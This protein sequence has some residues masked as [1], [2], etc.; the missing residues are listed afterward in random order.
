MIWIFLLYL[1]NTILM[2]IL[3]IREVRRP[4]KAL[5]WLVF[6]LVLPIIGFGLYLSTTNPMRIR[7]KRLTPSNNELDLLPDSFSHSATVI[8]N[9]LHPLTVGGLR[10]ARVEVLINGI[11]TYQNLIN[12]LEKAEKAID[13]EY[14][15][16]KYD[17][18]GKQFTD[19]LIERARAGVQ[20]RFLRDGVGSRKFPRQ[21]IT[22]MMD[23]GIECRTIFPMR[24]PWFLS[25]WNYRDHC[26][27]VTIDGEE[28]FTGGINVGLEYT[29]LKPDVGFW[30]DTHLR[31]KGNASS[32]LQKIFEVHW[33]LAV[34]ERKKASKTYTK[35][36]NL[37]G[38]QNKDP[39][40]AF[41][42]WSEE[43]SHELSDMNEKNLNTESVHDAYV[44]TLEGNP[45]VPTP[46]TR[47]AYFI[48]LTQAT[49]TIDMTTPYFVPDEDILMAMKTA[50]A[51]G[52]RVRLLVPRRVNQKV[53]GPASRTYYGDLLEAG[54]EIFLYDKGMLHAKEVI[55]DEEM[56]GVGTVNFDMRSFRLNYESWEM[57]YSNDVAKQLESQ[58]ETDLT[59]STRLR[60]ENLTERTLPQRII[61]QGARL[62]SPLL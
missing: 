22:R 9:S 60:M 1:F 6:C 10:T 17:Q 5:N 55:I 31:I 28:A 50:I 2:I 24:F 14:Y 53:V 40:M 54:V 35:T 49:R 47:N 39:S 21:Q 62:L 36:E 56:V 30:R 41:S 48:C 34:P 45:G 13:L 29:G 12:H 44:Q 58:F 42:G 23:A 19:I 20:I 3:A 7:R 11:P 16:F 38:S 51:R 8:A 37:Q 4:A 59:E 25:N 27:I 33:N 52:V 46:I 57:V 26:K 18:V 32:D 43:L 61:Q 15:I